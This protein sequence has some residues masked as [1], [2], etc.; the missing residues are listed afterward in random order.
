MQLLLLAYYSSATVSILDNLIIFYRVE[1]ELSSA[2]KVK[3][4]SVGSNT[5]DLYKDLLID[6]NVTA[7]ACTR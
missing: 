5:Q 4:D 6:A 2:I 3:K 7:L 1:N